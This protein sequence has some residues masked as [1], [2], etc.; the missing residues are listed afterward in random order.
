MRGNR[1]T[2]ISRTHSPGGQNAA[3]VPRVG[4]LRVISAYFGYSL[5][6]MAA[7][8][9]HL[10][11]MLASIDRDRLEQVCRAFAVTKLAVFGSMAR[12]EAT[13]DSDVDILVDFDPGAGATY[14]TLVE[15]S[16]ALSPLF[17]GRRVD[18]GRLQQLH[19]L[20]RER[21][22]ADAKVLYA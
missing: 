20:M 21:V 2:A 22:L 8:L 9:E 11:P 6:I 15:L 1:E 18:V 13:P 19:W 5:S 10:P 4:I 14:F 3:L 12:G 17:N 7:V 16:D